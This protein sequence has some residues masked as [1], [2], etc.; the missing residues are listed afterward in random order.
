M[1]SAPLPNVAHLQALA[2]LVRF[3]CLKVAGAEQ[4]AHLLSALAAA[5]VMT[6]L[7]FGGSFRF[8]LNNPGRPDN[9]RL[10]VPEEAAFPLFHA[11]W[12]VAGAIDESA[13][14]TPHATGCWLDQI[15]GPH[16]GPSRAASGWG[17]HHAVVGFGLGRLALSPLG[18]AGDPPRRTYVL[19]N[20]TA[21]ADNA[22]W[23]LLQQAARC[24]VPNLVGISNVSRVTHKH[25]KRPVGRD[26]EAYARRIAS[27]G[28]KTLLID[29]HGYPQILGALRAAAA[30]TDQAVMIIART[31]KSDGLAYLDGQNNPR[32]LDAADWKHALA[33]ID[34]IDHGLRGHIPPPETV[35][36][37]PQPPAHLVT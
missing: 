15:S 30:T 21:S 20:G 36:R 13:L 23:G 11:L 31:L 5:D 25:Q 3:H 6:G 22:R 9:D 27:C 16:A 10:L 7:L 33:A 19:L 2:R 34:N 12:A 18:G 32:S 14:E 26:I 29:G 24:R 37:R 4:P 1:S 28:W 8:D 17:G 35:A